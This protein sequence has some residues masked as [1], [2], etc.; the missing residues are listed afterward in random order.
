MATPTKYDGS[1]CSYCRAKSRRM[2]LSGRGAKG[3]MQHSR[4][5]VC[6]NGHKLYRKSK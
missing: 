1:P 3:R 2:Y 4:W 5:H 6:E